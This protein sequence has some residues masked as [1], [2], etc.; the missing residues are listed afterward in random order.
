MALFKLWYYPKYVDE[1]DEVD[2]EIEGIDF[3]RIPP[4]VNVSEWK[5][6]KWKEPEWILPKLNRTT[7]NLIS[8]IEKFYNTPERIYFLENIKNILAEPKNPE[9]ALWVPKRPN[10]DDVLNAY[11][12]YNKICEN[13]HNINTMD[14]ESIEIFSE[15]FNA[16]RDYYSGAMGLNRIITWPAQKLFS[17]DLDNIAGRKQTLLMESDPIAF[18]FYTETITTSS[19]EEVNGYKLYDCIKPFMTYDLYLHHLKERLKPQDTDDEFSKWLDENCCSDWAKQDRNGECYAGA[20]QADEGTYEKENAWY[21]TNDDN[22]KGLMALPFPRSLIKWSIIVGC[23]NR[24]ESVRYSNF[25]GVWFE[26]TRSICTAEIP[27]L[28]DFCKIEM[29]R[30]GIH[31]PEFC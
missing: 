9:F 4:I 25:I 6:P 26:R 30:T 7:Q 13:L 31:L 21:I 14:I 18:K 16:F 23:S 24:Q 3:I 8:E 29:A 17:V 2:V 20:W 10:R 28:Q 19:V 15:E 22:M 5:E 11:P 27:S 1:V 12:T